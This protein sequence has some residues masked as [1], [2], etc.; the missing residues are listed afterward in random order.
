MTTN[1]PAVAIDADQLGEITGTEYD[2]MLVIT[3]DGGKAVIQKI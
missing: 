1:T 2:P 3:K